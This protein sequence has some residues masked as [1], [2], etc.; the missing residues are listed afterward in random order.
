[1]HLVCRQC[2]SRLSSDLQ[3]VSLSERNET[4][5]EEFLHRGT[6]MQEDGSY[7]QGRTG[8]YIV[9]SEDVVHVQLTSDS[10]RLA[11]CCG[12]DGCDGPNLQ[13]EICETYVATKITDCWRPHCVVFE[14]ATTRLVSEVNS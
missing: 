14:S 6:V 2:S 13:C 10:K 4:M 11:G 5:G 7:F 8:E 1:M 9:H 12:L 3:P